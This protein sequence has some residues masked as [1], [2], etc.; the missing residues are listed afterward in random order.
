MKIR[1]TLSALSLTTLVLSLAAC[2]KPTEADCEKLGDH[3]V[4]L[5]AKELGGEGDG[6]VADAIREEATK[7]RGALVKECRENGSKSEVECIMKAQSL[8]DIEKC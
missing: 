7:E 5:M 1:S 3:V 8:A 4:E 6:P 2:S